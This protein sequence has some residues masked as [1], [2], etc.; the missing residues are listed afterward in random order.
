[1][2]L[3]MAAQVDFFSSCP[4]LPVCHL[5]LVSSQRMSKSGSD[6]NSTHSRTSEGQGCAAF[7]WYFSESLSFRPLPPP[8]FTYCCY[9]PV[10]GSS[11]HLWSSAC[12]VQSCSSWSVASEILANFLWKLLFLSFKLIKKKNGGFGAHRPT[13]ISSILIFRTPL[14][15]QNVYR[16][17][18]DLNWFGCTFMHYTGMSLILLFGFRIH[19]IGHRYYEM[20]CHA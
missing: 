13:C 16:Q 4:P 18:C 6:R 9:H 8:H 12:E 14:L 10:R 11:S 20:I 19:V 7:L 2:L 5:P 17:T 15:F 3:V 1:M